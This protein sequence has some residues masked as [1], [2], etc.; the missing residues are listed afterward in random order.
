MFK[1]SIFTCFLGGLLVLCS[2]G[3]HAQQPPDSSIEHHSSRITNDTLAGDTLLHDTA[4]VLQNAD[5]LRQAHNT[6]AALQ[7][8]D[9]LLLDTVAVLKP[10]AKKRRLVLPPPDTVI[11]DTAKTPRIFAFTLQRSTNDVLRCDIDTTLRAMYIDYP[12]LRQDVGANF[13]GNLGSPALAY[14]YFLRSTREDFLFVQPYTPYFF[15]PD[16]A[17]HYNTT[18]PYTLLYYDWTLR[19]RTEESQLRVLHTQSITNE[20]SFGVEFN[21][22][23]AK[24]IYQRQSVSNKSLHAFVS[25]LGKY[26]SANLGYINN[27]VKGQENGGLA[28]DSVIYD[29]DLEPITVGVRLQRA[30]NQLKQSTFYLTHS[31]DFPLLYLGNDS[32]IFNIIKG[33]LGHSFE[34]T[35]YSKLYTDE[36][37]DPTFYPTHYLNNSKTRDSLGLR[38]LE[39]RF[40]LQ[41]RPLRAYIFES[42]AGGIGFRKFTSYMFDPAMYLSDLQ[43][44]KL[45]S[46]FLYASASAWYKQYFLLSAYVE[47][48]MAGYAAGD[49]TFK[50]DLK[51]SAYPIRQ[52]IHLLAKLEIDLR[53]PSIFYQNYSSNYYQWHHDYTNSLEDKIKEYKL[54]G[55][56]SIPY[57]QTVATFKY[58]LYD[59]YIY[60]GED[61]LPAQTADPINIVA[62]RIDQNFKLWYFHFNHRFLLQTSSMPSALDL[63]LLSANG[64]YYIEYEIVKNVLRAQLGVDAQYC[65]PYNGYGYDPSIGM[66]YNTPQ[67]VGGY[68]WL[69]VFLAMR[70][71]SA[72]PFIKYEHA[73]QFL[74]E[75]PHGY[76]AAVHYPRNARVFKIGLSWKF[77]D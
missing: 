56:L 72:T 55:T 41:I 75:Q 12:F 49:V 48:V 33:R 25:Y 69:D 68:L 8:A 10:I 34:S 51:L 31:I 38:R 59:K 27:S 46:T 30:R 64:N 5:T 70:W 54:E 7:S 61:H 77:F 1:V 17:M 26:Y 50:T 58:S 21:N 15:T 3:A 4:I 53:R 40:F 62:L 2:T 39:N 60:F 57:T 37:E 36:N 20:L 73:N 6:T 14:D 22:I 74:W 45:N 63:P 66:F 11:I 65:T 43:S 18:T 42:L 13:L 29:Q 35:S 19:R 76:F 71:K 44:Q 32:L 9:S 24:G 28:G 23:N 16:N 52:G 67:K 47:T